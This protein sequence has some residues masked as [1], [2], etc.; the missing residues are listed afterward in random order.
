MAGDVTA[1]GLKEGLKQGVSGGD[2]F[3]LRPN[4]SV[5]LFCNAIDDLTAS[6]LLVTPARHAQG[7]KEVFQSGE[8]QG[9]VR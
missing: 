1:C 9:C 7:H 3:H 5:S 4:V 6:E 8:Q 2:T